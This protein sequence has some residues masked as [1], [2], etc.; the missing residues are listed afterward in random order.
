MNI[1]QLQY[2]VMTVKCGSYAT[3]AKRMY[4][5]APAVS[6]SIGDLEKELR[7]KLLERMGRNVGPTQ[8]GT[9]FYHKALSV[10]EGITELSNMA[11]LASSGILKSGPLKIAVAISPLRGNFIDQDLFRRFHK[12]HTEFPISVVCN[13]SGVCLSALE[14]NIVDAAIVLGSIDKPGL[15]ATKL[16]SFSPLVAISRKHPLS[17]RKSLG[18]KDLS[19]CRIARPNDLRFVYP[20]ITRCFHDAGYEPNFVDVYP[21]QEDHRI[22][23]H[24]SLGVVIVSPDQKLLDLYE[25]VTLVP[26]AHTDIEI[27]VS[28]ARLDSSESFAIPTLVNYIRI[29]EGKNRV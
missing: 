2:F 5:T 25:T 7:V 26:I 15:L 10:L 9:T 18:I 20:L 13:S 16:Y 19:T 23:L 11:A 17:K 22:F 3:A 28:I 14:E 4:V 21:S 8:F 27:P 29:S 1:G 24:D 6:K 12:E